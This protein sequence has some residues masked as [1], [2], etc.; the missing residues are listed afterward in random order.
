[1]LRR[2]DV[3]RGSLFTPRCVIATR[4][5]AALPAF[6]NHSFRFESPF[7]FFYKIAFVPRV[8]TAAIHRS[9]RTLCFSTFHFP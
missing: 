3:I 8:I 7:S 5:G 2:N 9:R 1:M 6:F 4:G